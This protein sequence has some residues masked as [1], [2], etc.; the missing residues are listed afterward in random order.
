MLPYST[1]K[2]TYLFVA[3]CLALPAQKREA[4]PDY[5]GWPFYSKREANPDFIDWEYYAKRDANPDFIDWPFYS[6]R[7]AKADPDALIRNKREA[8]P[9]PAHVRFRK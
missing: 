1:M 2:F 6:K 4:N 5:I 3:S 7:D 9:E 8:Q